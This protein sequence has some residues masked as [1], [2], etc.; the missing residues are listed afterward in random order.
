MFDIWKDYDPQFYNDLT[1]PDDAVSY[2]VKKYYY[3]GLTMPDM[4]DETGQKWSI[5]I[6]KSLSNAHI[7]TQF[8]TAFDISDD[9]RSLLSTV[10]NSRIIK[11]ADSDSVAPNH[12]L[13]GCYAAAEYARNQGWS[14]VDKA[15]LYGQ[16]MH[17][18]QDQ[19]AH[20]VMQPSLF[21]YGT[22]IE[23]KYDNQLVKNNLLSKFEFYYEI[24]VP[25][26]IP[27]F[28]FVKQ[29][30]RETATDGS[31]STFGWGDFNSYYYSFHRTRN[32]INMTS[33]DLPNLS[34]YIEAMIFCGE[35]S[36]QHLTFDRLKTL[37]H[38]WGL[39]IFL[40]S[41]Y[42]A[43]GLYQGGLYNRP[44]LTVDQYADFI[45][46]MGDPQGFM[47]QDVLSKAAITYLNFI[48]MKSEITS[49]DSWGLQSI[50][51][52]YHFSL[53]L[54]KLQ[55]FTPIISVFEDTLT[56]DYLYN[57][58]WTDKT[59]HS[60]SMYEQLRDNIATFEKYGN[61]YK[62]DR[63]EAYSGEISR[64]I[65]MKKFYKHQL[66]LGSINGPKYLNYSMELPDVNK[67][68]ASIFTL[69]RKAGILG[70]IIP[71]ASPQHSYYDQPGIIDMHF[72]LNGQ[73][74]Y[75]SASVKI[76]R[77][78]AYEKIN[79]DYKII[80]FGITQIGIGRKWNG[81]YDEHT[82]NVD[83][84]AKIEGQY[85]LNTNCMYDDNIKTVSYIVK[86]RTKAI[87]YSYSKM[88]D[89]DYRQYYNNPSL[90]LN[91]NAEY[92]QAFH[93]G[94]PFRK[95]NENP[96]D[97]VENLWPYILP[98]NYSN[99]INA[100]GN[101]EMTPNENL[102][103]G[104]LSW[105]N[106]SRFGNQFKI[107]KQKYGLQ[108]EYV[109]MYSDTFA[110]ISSLE[111]FSEYKFYIQTINSDSGFYSDTVVKELYIMPYKRINKAYFNSS[112]NWGTR[113]ISDN[114]KLF[115][116]Y[117]DGNDSVS[118][119]YSTDNGLHWSPS[120]KLDGGN[121]HNPSLCV[122]N[123]TIYAVWLKDFYN[124]TVGKKLGRIRYAKFAYNSSSVNPINL[125]ASVPSK[126][127]CHYQD[128]KNQ[129]I[130]KMHNDSIYILC[131]STFDFE[132]KHYNDVNTY[133]FD[134]TTSNPSTVNP[135]I[136][137]IPRNNGLNNKIEAYFI[138][139]QLKIFYIAGNGLYSYDYNTNTIDSLD[140]N[141]NNYFIGKD[142]KTNKIDIL[143]S[144]YSETAKHIYYESGWHTEDISNYYGGAKEGVLISYDNYISMTY[145]SDNHFYYLKKDPTGNW[146]TGYLPQYSGVYLVSSVEKD[147]GLAFRPYYY[148]Y[149]MML[150][151]ENKK[152]LINKQY[153][154]RGG[155]AS[156]KDK[157]IGFGNDIKSI[158]IVDGRKNLIGIRTIP[159]KVV[160]SYSLSKASPVNIEICDISG[161]S[162]KKYNDPYKTSGN[163]KIEITLPKGIYFIKARSSEWNKNKKFAIM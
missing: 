68:T 139:N 80:N 106:E 161:R 118:Y 25:T 122:K 150:Y 44:D 110:T 152:V 26:N 104:I 32:W 21:G 119:T 137:E 145:K 40:Q 28:S 125:K 121:V 14:S 27:D 94:N 97:N 9:E 133:L 56:V 63:P 30:F 2:L 51:D 53:D 95:V 100:P 155:M 12:N 91:D 20:M 153:I 76:R 74:V 69:S 136:T 109:G 75:D 23:S 99:I 154:G 52:V 70:G 82:Q 144:Q 13:E 93:N 18:I 90:H 163:Y 7:I 61:P 8:Y 37:M 159:G 142:S 79:V 132:N 143:S 141:C 138:N 101:V 5:K 98:V 81:G 33:D 60:D 45:G 149:V 147:E 66:E 57:N 116:V 146:V 1:N 86:S 15:L 158:K 111:P 112:D 10:G 64:I 151:P 108:K 59:P 17:V 148:E 107:W 73:F 22:A 113:I 120:V 117:A 92:V 89:S 39:L 46:Q 38:G 71:L 156:I 67:Q 102:N 11:F 78:D 131:Q 42:N 4:L 84:T 103:S 41:G 3:I 62:F 24:M 34:K 130:I 162:I 87:P 157:S 50:I 49:I 129:P 6:L 140:N 19:Y 88:I 47:I 31:Q 16:L 96:Y 77:E 160:I 55:G 65:S 115:M 48:A 123:D 72:A 124:S 36:P 58:L 128:F 43:F 126:A 85:N 54:L 83:D 127:Q 29:M 135:S 105:H 114:G 35:F 134:K